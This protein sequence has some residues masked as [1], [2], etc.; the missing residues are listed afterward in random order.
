MKGLFFYCFLR[1]LVKGVARSGWSDSVYRGF[2]EDQK[3]KRRVI[4]G[5]GVIK[6]RFEDV[7]ETMAEG[8]GRLGEGAGMKPGGG[9]GGG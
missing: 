9:G 4:R 1:I 8:G 3:R 7:R 6:G 5:L 2:L